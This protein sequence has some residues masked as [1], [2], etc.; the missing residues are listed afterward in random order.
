MQFYKAQ[1]LL[2]TEPEENNDRRLARRQARQ[3]SIKC[4][5]YNAMFAGDAY[6]LVSS[7]RDDLVNFCAVTTKPR[8]FEKYFSGFVKCTEWDI[9]DIT[10][11]EITFSTFQSMLGY[12]MREGYVDDD[13]EILEMFG[14]DSLTG[15]WGR[16]MSYGENLLEELSRDKIVSTCEKYLATETFLPEIERIYLGKSKSKAIGHPVHYILET[17]NRDIRKELYKALLSALYDCGRVQNRRYAYVDFGPAADFS[18]HTYDALYNSCE[19]GTMVVR[20]APVSGMEEGEYASTDREVLRTI[21]QQILKYRNKVLTILCLPRECTKIKELLFED[22]DELCYIELSE[23]LARG[24]AAENYLKLLA[25]ESKTRADKKLF[26]AI[27][28]KEGYLSTDLHKIFDSWYDKKLRASIYPQYKE[29]KKVK[30]QI[31]NA[32]PKGSAYDKLSEMVGL[33][34][35]KEV[36]A[37]ALDFY[38]AQKLFKDKGMN[39]DHPSMHLIFTGNPGSAKTTVARLFAEIMRDNGVLSKGH[40]VECGR[41]DLVGKYVGWTAVQVKKLFKDAKGGVLFI[42]EAYSL[43]DDRD[44]SFG[45]EA[46]NTI[47]QEMENH[48]DDVVCIFAGYPDKMEG[49]LQKNPGLRS[50]IAFHVSFDDYSSKELCEITKLIAKDKGFKL[51]DAAIEKL[52]EIYEEAIKTPDFGNGRAARNI[53]EKARMAQ[54]SRLVK[55]DFDSISK[56]DISTIKA[57]DIIA[58]EFKKSETKHIG[59]CA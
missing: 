17:D 46:I 11:E 7:V 47:V 34:S 41:A 15:R 9:T 27:D 30:T 6:F 36:I 58:P 40:I 24:E 51:D 25:K 44:G 10:S 31:Q 12:A 3:L 38:K 26:E 53:V 56:E 39:E 29:A 50:R 28:E 22:M 5:E 4:D 45:D 33:A 49:F 20:Y 16:N 19:G 23:D 13:D 8:Q 42:D 2:M 55:M 59:F 54:A 32:T 37:N 57:E 43:C 18:R 35:A 21:G 14:L 1:G 48:R 52:S